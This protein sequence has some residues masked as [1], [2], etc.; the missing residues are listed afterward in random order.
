MLSYEQNLDKLIT[1]LLRTWILKVLS[2][3]RLKFWKDTGGSYIIVSSFL[4]EGH[5]NNS[6]SLSVVNKQFPVS[7]YRA[8]RYM[9]IISK[10]RIGLH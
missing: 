4:M 7:M 5:L 2:K 8:L 9:L 10:I 3:S 6:H 1:I